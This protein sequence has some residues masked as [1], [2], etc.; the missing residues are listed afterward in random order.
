MNVEGLRNELTLD[1]APRQQLKALETAD[2]SLEGAGYNHEGSLDLGFNHCA[3]G[4]VDCADSF[5]LARDLTVDPN[6]VVDAQRSLPLRS[7][8]YHVGALVRCCRAASPP[9]VLGVSKGLRISRGPRLAKG[10]R[11]PQA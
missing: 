3:F 5:D 11:F 10:L 1:S 8:R 7:G 2:F 4:N 6:A 9:F